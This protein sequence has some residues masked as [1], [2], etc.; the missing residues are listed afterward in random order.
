MTKHYPRFRT[1]IL[2]GLLTASLP[3]L[4]TAQSNPSLYA[5][6]FNVFTQTGITL[7][8]GDTHGPLATGGNLTLNGAAILSMNYTGTYPFGANNANNYGLVVNGRIYYTS[9][10]V[11]TLNQG[12]L[13]LGNVTG[14]T[15]YD[16][17]NNGASSNLQATSGSYGSSPRLE[18]QR[19]QDKT[20]A[21]TASGIDFVAAFNEFNYNTALINSYRN[22]T[23]CAGNF[24]YI[25]IPSGVS[26]P[27][28]TLMTGKVNYIDLTE[29][30]LNNLNT[31]GSITFTNSPNANRLL[32][33]NVRTTNGTYSWT[34]FNA[35]GLNESDA[36]Y[37]LLNFPDATNLT[38]AG[39]NAVYSAIYAPGANVNKT[40]NGNV[41]AQI[42]A[43]SLSMTSSGEIHYYPFAGSLPACGNTAAGQLNNFSSVPLS[44]G[45]ID[46]YISAKNDGNEL[47]WKVANEKD[48][49]AY[50]AERSDDGV[51]FRTLSTV[52]AVGNAPVN[53]YSAIDAQP[54]T[55]ASTYY[56]IVAVSKNGLMQYSN[57]VQLRAART[58]SSATAWP[59]PF[60]GTL[61]VQAGAGYEAGGR[62]QITD[63]SGRIVLA[64]SFTAGAGEV[65]RIDEA[66]S[67]IPGTYVLSLMAAN[68]SSKSN[69]RVVKN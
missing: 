32:I 48:M 36:A 31:Q 57:T 25:T 11:S 26:N 17:D 46:L 2:T 4:S 35:A 14:T 16:H 12:Y 62:L 65:I 38:I 40:S 49:L 54:A 56:R 13:R 1:A 43:K 29:S 8:N 22:T 10:Q 33:I 66:S 67:L 3:V 53:A 6:G 41:N 30:Q 19:Y 69:L 20:T 58:G 51:S 63:L 24:N 68:G 45:S 39:S 50:K 27:Q 59:T 28:I 55:G 34:P 21:T 7:Q 52:T 60:S 37:I 47:A 5:N 9:G 61:S 64:K 42:I 23:T 15:L 18:V 44:V